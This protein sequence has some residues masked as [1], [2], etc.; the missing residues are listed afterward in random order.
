MPSAAE[1][2]A[3][4]S[5][6][7]E[8]RKRLAIPAFAGGVLYL[9]SSIIISATLNG[10]PT[11]GLLQG[12]TPALRGETTPEVSPRAPEV[13]WISHHAF[14][15]ISG[16]VLAAVAVLILTV[17]LLLFA[18][19]TYFRRPETWALAR[20]LVLVGG[21]SVAVLG[22]GH[23]V[24]SAIETHNF[25]VGH[26]H[27]NA[28]VDHA[29]TKATPNVIVGYLALLAGLALAA[30][31]ISVMLGSQRVGLVPRWMGILGI[32]SGLLIFLPIGGAQLQI[33]PAFW[34]VMTG[35]LLLG[36]W[37]SGD[38]PA[39]E[40]G[41]ARPWPTAAE[42]R[43]ARAAGGRDAGKPAPAGA[44]AATAAAPAAAS[45]GRRRK[46]KGRGR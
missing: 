17:V 26:D 5:L 43:A 34:L 12:L 6:E 29:L 14:P 45:G 23:Q 46:R 30:G 44:P 38:P 28:A 20:P 2:R 33:I 18:D 19:A 22:I 31:M 40:A 7:L 15:L 32:F 16:S 39:W 9:L 42:Q 1:I 13:K 37:P 24:V 11:V 8:R 10:A 27:T 4:T 21:I 41:E 25:A 3:Q 35:V 36:R